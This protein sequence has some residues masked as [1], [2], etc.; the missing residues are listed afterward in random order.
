MSQ[1][2]RPRACSGIESSLRAERPDGHERR[3]LAPL[4][5]L[6]DLVPLSLALLGTLFGY[7]SAT[8]D[9]SPHRYPARRA[10]GGAADAGCDNGDRSEGPGWGTAGGGKYFA[11]LSLGF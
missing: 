9:G 4:D 5:L 1:N 10:V 11:Q 8:V 7:R 3:S 2:Q 6:N